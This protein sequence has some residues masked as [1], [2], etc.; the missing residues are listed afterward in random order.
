MLS[1]PSMA[2]QLLNDKLI[3][4]KNAEVAILATSNIGCSLH[5][6]KGLKD[7]HLN[8]SI[9]HPIQIIAKQMGFNNQ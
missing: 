2:N 7:Q 9:C 1:Q 8:V 3:A 5:I 4:I 6:A